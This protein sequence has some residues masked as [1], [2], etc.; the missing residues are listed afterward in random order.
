MTHK[1]STP[2][3]LHIEVGKIAA[4]V[5]EQ[6]G[7]HCELR[8]DPA[9][10]SSK[11]RRLPLVNGSTKNRATIYCFVDALVMCRGRVR[12]VI[13]I[14]ESDVKPTQVCGKFL[15]SA[16]SS[17]Y[18]PK[19]ESAIRLDTVLWFIQVVNSRDFRDRSR[20]LSQLRHLETSIQ[21]IPRLVGDIEYRLLDVQDGYESRLQSY[22]QQALAEPLSPAAAPGA[23]RSHV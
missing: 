1:P 22:L 5:V 21:R 15:T 14:E 17:H 19:G 4:G 3:G 8:M 6:A 12:V 11:G 10:S 9:C 16:L 7:D 18:I 23:G 2:H 20:K 13:E